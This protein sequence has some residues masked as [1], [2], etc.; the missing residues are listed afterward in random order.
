MNDW[1]RDRRYACIIALAEQFEHNTHMIEQYGNLKKILLLTFLLT[2]KMT[3]YMEKEKNLMF[4]MRT[5]LHPR[6]RCQEELWFPL[7]SLGTAPKK[8][9]FC[10]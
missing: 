3:G 4:Q 8:R 7:Q 2:Y 9:F 6:I 10:E 1:C 5:C